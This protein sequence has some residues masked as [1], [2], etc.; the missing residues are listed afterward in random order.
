MIEWLLERFIETAK[1][2]PEV[3]IY[4]NRLDAEHL[5][6]DKHL[7][8]FI[9]ISG[10]VE[11]ENF[12]I[13][14]NTFCGYNVISLSD[15]KAEDNV[16]IISRTDEKVIRKKLINLRL[17]KCRI[18]CF[19][20]DLIL[21]NSR[22]AFRKIGPSKQE[23]IS[24]VINDIKDWELFVKKV[25]QGR[26]GKQLE[27]YLELEPL[28]NQSQLLEISHREYICRCFNCGRINTYSTIYVGI[29][30]YF[31]C[32]ECEKCQH[33]WLRIQGYKNYN[34]PVV[35]IPYFDRCIYKK[36]GRA[37]QYVSNMVLAKEAIE[38]LRSF[39]LSF[40]RYSI[41]NKEIRWNNELNS[42]GDENTLHIFTNRLDSIWHN[43]I[44]EWV[45]MWRFCRTA[46]GKRHR[47]VAY[48]AEFVEGTS[49]FISSC[50]KVICFRENGDTHIEGIC[51]LN[52]YLQVHRR[53]YFA[54]TMKGSE[55]S[56]YYT[57]EEEMLRDWFKKLDKK[58]EK[59]KA[60]YREYFPILFFYVRPYQEIAWQPQEENVTEF[61]RLFLKKYRKGLIILH[62]N[63]SPENNEY[64]RSDSSWMKIMGKKRVVDCI[65]KNFDEQYIMNKISHLGLFHSGGGR[66]ITHLTGRPFIEMLN[67]YHLSLADDKFTKNKEKIYNWAYNRNNREEYFALIDFVR[68]GDLDYYFDPE[69]VLS[70]V[71]L[72]LNKLKNQ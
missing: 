67:S 38:F 30:H 26:N 51:K 17:K 22:K 41:N 37:S 5:I 2:I 43:F 42:N 47:I 39:V 61:V 68:F 53:Y 55:K 19:F 6:K 36:K 66:T 14:E 9:K 64:Y 4:A 59:L 40:F 18:I 11:H 62:G 20:D 63:I 60:K 48:T 25:Y 34:N 49:K 7:D 54:P 32:F 8:R 29:H 10:F 23:H 12:D 71:S 3:A 21:P 72:M 46:Y 70:A 31:I 44:D 16:L 50:D 28:L 33:K 52:E 1:H 27:D 15:L 35:Y 69:F 56:P 13:K 57:F 24:E 65:N 45:I 58:A